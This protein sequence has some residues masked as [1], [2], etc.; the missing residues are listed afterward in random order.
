[1]VGLGNLGYPRKS[2]VALMNASK[3][4]EIF[5]EKHKAL[6]FNSSNSTGKF[7]VG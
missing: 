1:M 2:Y 6:T 4:Q 7:T 5:V 3:V